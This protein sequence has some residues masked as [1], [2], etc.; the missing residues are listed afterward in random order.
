MK[1]NINWASPK[2]EKI[3]TEEIKKSPD[4]LSNAFKAIADR[5]KCSA[6][7]VSYRWYNTIRFKVEIFQTSSNKITKVNGKNTPREVR[8]NPRRKPIYQMVLSSQNLEGMKVFTVKQ[9][10]AA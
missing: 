3:F 9:F 5:L 6:S 10:F 2:T 1:K 8:Y 4:N 7:L